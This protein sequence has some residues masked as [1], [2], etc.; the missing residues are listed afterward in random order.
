MNQFR[1]LAVLEKHPQLI[2]ACDPTPKV[3]KQLKSFTFWQEYPSFAI[4]RPL[5]HLNVL[6]YNQR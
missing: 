2:E 4:H 5:F 1:L 6:D 3:S